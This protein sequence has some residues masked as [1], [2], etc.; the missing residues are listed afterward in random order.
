MMRRL[1]MTTGALLCCIAIA[2]AQ[3][4][5]SLEVQIHYKGSGTVDSSHKIFVALWES[6]DFNGGPP[7]EV[8]TLSSKDGSVTF[9]NIKATPVFASTA[10]DPSG[11]WDAT[12]P[13]PSGASVGMHSKEPPKPEPIPIAPGKVA[14]V[15]IT[16]DDTTKVP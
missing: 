16:F 5:G 14:K 7:S 8:K 15:T 11:S 6:D 2:L 1:L 4:G 3:E 12:S 9:S 13:P 10:F